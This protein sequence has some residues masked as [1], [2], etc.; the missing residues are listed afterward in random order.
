MFIGS[1]GCGKTTLTQRIQGEELKYS[2]TQ[3]IQFNSGI[4]D[5]PGEFI[6]HRGYYSALK[7]TSVEADVIAFVASLTE[8]NQIFPPL[9]SS[10]FTKPV[11]GIL[12]KIDLN[13][14]NRDITSANN[15]LYLAGV[16]EIFSVSSYTNEGI[17]EL[18]NYLNT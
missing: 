10:Y 13:T 12:T 7:V 5:T 14:P 3:S 15:R 16:K 17:E 9:F 1:T 2:K 18:V 6:Q 4:I 8:E 11:I